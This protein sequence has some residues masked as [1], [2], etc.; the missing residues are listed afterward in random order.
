LGTRYRAN[1]IF[2]SE[3][4]YSVMSLRRIWNSGGGSPGK[5]PGDNFYSAPARALRGTFLEIE[6]LAG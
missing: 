2:F 4:F 3:I 1:H 6:G 5:N